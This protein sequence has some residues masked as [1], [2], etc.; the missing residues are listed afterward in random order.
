MMMM[1]YCFRYIVIFSRMIQANVNN[2]T[3]MAVRRKGE[4]II[5]TY[6]LFAS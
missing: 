3:E 6:K 2:K 1:F 5:I 4:L